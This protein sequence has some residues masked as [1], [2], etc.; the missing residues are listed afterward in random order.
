[1]PE[2]VSGAEYAI[3]INTFRCEPS[4]QEVVQLNALHGP[5]GVAGRGAAHHLQGQ[6]RALAARG[7]DVDAELL[8]DPVGVELLDVVDRH[9][10]QLVGGDRGGRL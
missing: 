5:A 2:I 7:R 1:M 3:F 9:P 10:D 4:N 8:E 6:Q